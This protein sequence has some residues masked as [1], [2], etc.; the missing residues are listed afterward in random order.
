MTPVTP[1]GEPVDL[2]ASVA[3]LSISTKD[4]PKIRH[5]NLDVADE[6]KRSNLKDSASF[7][8]IGKGS[9]DTDFETPLT[10]HRAR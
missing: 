10:I 9:G 4:T 5:K 1:S 6:Y 7:V 8:V 2:D 3:S